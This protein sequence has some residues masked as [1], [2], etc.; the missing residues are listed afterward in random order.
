MNLLTPVM[1]E[2]TSDGIELLLAPPLGV[3]GN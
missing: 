1:S 3:S 2:N